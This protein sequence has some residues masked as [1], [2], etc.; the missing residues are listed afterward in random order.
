MYWKEGIKGQG[1]GR[2]QL[3]LQPQSSPNNRRTLYS[4][5]YVSQEL[6]DISPNASKDLQDTRGMPVSY[7]WQQGL[8]QTCALPVAHALPAQMQARCCR[9]GR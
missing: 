1:L 5:E 2:H 7:S 8:S 3:D 6:Y 4:I 9:E